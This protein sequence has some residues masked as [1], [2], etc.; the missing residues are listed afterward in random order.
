MQI[1]LTAY[2]DKAGELIPELVGLEDF[3]QI[4][5]TDVVRGNVDD[6]QWFIDKL[7]ERDPR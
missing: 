3:W 1:L 4:D 6:L 7:K 5:F 2:T